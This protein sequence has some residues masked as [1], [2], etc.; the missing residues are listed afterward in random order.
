MRP[1]YLYVWTDVFSDYTNGIA[2]ALARDST[3]ARSQ[4][5]M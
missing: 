1:L 4:M 2:F 5:S 3:H